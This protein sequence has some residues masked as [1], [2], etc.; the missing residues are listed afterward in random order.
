MTASGPAIF[1]DGKSTARHHATVDVTPAV[2]RV[3]GADGALLAEWPYGEIEALAAPEGMLRLGK[4]ADPVLARLEIHDPK[5]AA[6]IDEL[7]IPVDRSGATERRLRRRV[8]AWSLAAAV[9]L[10]LVAVIGVPELATRM[11]PLVPYAA[12]RKFGAVVNAQIRQQLDSRKM[13]AAFQ[14]GASER[15]QPGR[16]AFA[17]LVG[18]IEAAAALPLPLTVAVVRRPDANAIAL[19][20]GYVYVFQGLIEKAQIPD[21]LAGVISHEIGHVAH[22]DEVRTVLGGAGLSLLFGMLLGDFVG[23]GAVVFAAKSIL[24]KNYSRQAEAEADAY[25]VNLMRK[26]GGDPRALG[27]ILTRLGGASH[28]GPRLLLDHPETAQRV[29]AIEAMAGAG[30]TRPLLSDAEWADLKRICASREAR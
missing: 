12:E 17:K 10:V 5:L 8:L 16:A 1:F 28:P 11:T 22:R 13:G 23:G 3:R 9:S 30:P 6:A 2:L 24:K 15:E 4:P 7:S 27:R 26:I 18:E 29:A 20:G 21:E 14:C 19:P 25:G